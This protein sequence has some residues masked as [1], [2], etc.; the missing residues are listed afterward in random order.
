MDILWRLIRLDRDEWIRSLAT[1]RVGDATHAPL[2]P[3]L[4]QQILRLRL[5]GER[6]TALIHDLHGEYK[7]VIAALDLQSVVPCDDVEDGAA[8]DGHAAEVL[9]VI[10]GEGGCSEEGADEDDGGIVFCEGTSVEGIAKVLGW[11]TS[12]DP[13]W[14][15]QGEIRE[16][17]ILRVGV[18]T[19]HAALEVLPIQVQ[20]G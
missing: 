8:V 18:V 14:R 4:R 6:G 5:L 1:P 17:G 12:Q 7:I 10:V 11:R 19:A 15:I 13:V 9:A 20:A 2:D 16:F 3:P